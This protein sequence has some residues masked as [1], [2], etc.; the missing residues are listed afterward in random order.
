MIWG[1]ITLNGRIG[2]ICVFNTSR[3]DIHTVFIKSSDLLL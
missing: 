1:V 3:E 2:V